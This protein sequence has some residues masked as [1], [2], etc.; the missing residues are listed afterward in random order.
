MRFYLTTPIYYVNS[1][2]H[3]G[4]AYTTIAA[5]IVVRHHRQRGDETYFLTGVDEHADKVAR[6]AAEQ[7]LEPR[8]YTD[9]IVGAWQ[10]VPRRVNATNDFFIRTSDEGHKAFVQD[11]LLRI[12]DNGHD[13]IYQDV[14][15][16]LYCFGCEAF[17]TE[18]ELVDGKCPDHGT[19]PEWIEERNWFFR[20]SAYQD[21]LLA[22][23]DEQPDFVLPQFRY[24]EARSF[25]AGGLRDFSISRATQTWGVPIPWD[26]EQVAYVWADALVN[27]LSALHY[28]PGENLERF[29]PAVHFLGKDILRFHCVYWPALLLAAGYER[30]RQLF[31]HGYLNIDQQK[32]SKSLGNAIDPLDLIDI[33]GADAVRFW[34]ARQVTFGQDGNV[35]LDS[36][37]ER[38]ETELANDLGNLVSRTTA[39]IARYREGR[40]ARSPGP[41]AFDAAAL[42]EAV[43]EQLRP[44]RHH[45]RARLDLAGGSCSQ[46]ARRGDGAVEPGQGRSTA[47]RA[48]H[49]S[50]R[51][52]RRDRG[53]RRRARAVSSRDRSAD[54]GGASSAGRPVARPGRARG[55]RGGRRD[56]ARCA[57]LPARRRAGAGGVIDT[58]AH[59]DALDDPDAAVSRA[60]EAG[61]GRILTV[62]TTVD[63]CRTALDLAERHEG[64]YAD[65]RAPPARG[66]RG[67]RRRRRPLDASCWITRARWPSARPGSTTSATTRRGTTSGGSFER[68]LAVAADTGKPVVVHTRAADE[69]TLVEL[70]GFAGTVVLHCFSS[71]DLLPAA[72]DRGYYVSFAGNDDLP[73]GGRPAHGG[74][75]DPGRPDPGRDR[76]AVPGA[77]ARPRPAERARERCSHPCGARRGARA[78]GSRAREAIEENAAAAFSLP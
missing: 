33:Y 12:R 13:D 77:A 53:R 47:D 45:R 4:H 76:R 78:G 23:Y 38:Y 59:L 50:L 39:M 57:A 44:L 48:G 70:D 18:D 32:I 24:N 3:I 62:G 5:D 19:V 22:I 36:F 51:P 40:L 74:R 10:E 65:P 29:W 35:S 31:V 21:R 14:Y 1:T 63:G 64:V 2:P 71:T 26:P 61:V 54:P 25:I 49:R 58:H 52:R 42:R 43:V 20:L 37:G 46:P 28:A 6:V 55:G 27:Y 60:L 72:L 56:R 30:P 69:D 75:T 41:G 7:G 8:A 15:A 67:R 68:L 17:K 16:G 73:E 66:R 34:C 11:F 9:R